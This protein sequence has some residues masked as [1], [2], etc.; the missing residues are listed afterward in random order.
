M[1]FSNGSVHHLTWLARDGHLPHGARVLDFGSQNFYGEL[2]DEAGRALF[3][4]FG[5]DDH[6]RPE[7][8]ANA[9]KIEGL[10]AALGLDYTAFDMYSAGHTKKFDFNFD[11]LSFFQ[12]GKFDLV[13]NL[14]T[15]EHVCNQ[16]NLFKQAHDALKVGGIAYHFVPF[17]GGPDHCLVNYHPKFFATLIANNAYK[18][19]YFD[20]SENFDSH[21][22]SYKGI[23]EVPGGAAWQAKH[24]GM[25]MTNVVVKKTR[26][27]RFQPP[28]D[29]VMA[30]DVSIEPPSMN[31]LMAQAAPT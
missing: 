21:W 1:G 22:N 10:M 15:S 8:F 20:F 19:L 7:H 24:I 13:M 9:T 5:R 16:F 25:A 4:A 14:G 30:G 29:G 2:T 12:R 6:Y 17:F 31:D 23:D 27:A 3:S 18:P 11:R 26:K 28:T